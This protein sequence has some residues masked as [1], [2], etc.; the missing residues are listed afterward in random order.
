MPIGIDPD[1][2]GALA[3]LDAVGALV[4][5]CDTPVLH[6]PMARGRAPRI[7]CAWPGGPPGALRWPTDSCAARRDPGP[8][9]AKGYAQCS[10]VSSA[11]GPDWACWR[12]CK[13]RIRPSAPRC[14]RRLSAWARTKSRPAVVSASLIALVIRSRKPFFKS[15]PSPYLFMATLF[16]VVVTLIVPFTPLGKIFGLS[17]LPMAFPLL[18][19]MIL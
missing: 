2:S 10:P 17:Q 19:G 13:S 15:R 9:P 7:R 6:L 5:L 4:A 8:C 18:I 1:L 12:R 16:V 11:W 3:V 14:G